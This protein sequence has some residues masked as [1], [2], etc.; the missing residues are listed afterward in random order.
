MNFLWKCDENSLEIWTIS[1]RNSGNF[2]WIFLDAVGS[3]ITPK[4]V[5]GMASNQS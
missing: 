3:G 5:R 2:Y 1:S 4:L